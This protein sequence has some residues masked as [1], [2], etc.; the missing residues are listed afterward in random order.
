[1]PKRFEQYKSLGTGLKK[2]E[3]ILGAEFSVWAP[4]AKSVCVVGEFNGWHPGINPMNQVESG[5]FQ[6]FIPGVAAGMKYQY[7]IE[8]LQGK[9]YWKAD[10]FARE[11]EVRPGRSSV[12]SD[13]SAWSW[14]DDQWMKKRRQWDFRTSPLGIYEVHIGSWRKKQDEFYTYREFAHEAAEYVLEMGYTHVELMGI[15]EHPCDA[16]WGYQ[17]TGYYAPTSRYGSVEDFAYMIDYFHQKNIGVI[18]DWVPAHFA[19]DEHGLVNFDGTPVFEYAD[20]LHGNLTAWGTLRFDYGK[21]FVREFLIGN[22]LFWVEEFHLDGLR[23]DAVAFMVYEDYLGYEDSTKCEKTKNRYNFEAIE[24]IK[25]LNK[26]MKAYHPDVL[27][28]A[29]ESSAFPGVT[30][31]QGLEFHMKWNMG[32]MH[33]LLEYV[34]MNQD[35]R[36]KN[37][38]LLTF[39]S[40]YMFDEKYL[41]A[42]SHDEVVHLKKSMLNK[43]SGYMDEKFSDLKVVYAYMIG[44]PGKKLLFM[45]QEFAQYAEWDEKKELDWYLLNDRRHKGVWN[46]WKDL[47]HLYKN[48]QALFQAD[49]EKEGFRWLNADD[50]K[51]SVYS[52]V[53]YGGENK[54]KWMFVCNFSASDWKSYR[55]GVPEWTEY[56]LRIDSNDVKYGGESERKPEVYVPELQEANGENF[57]F[58]F[59]ISAHNALI[60]TF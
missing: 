17:V 48:N 26:M 52:F 30:G 41:L 4:G 15:A 3:G 24:M 33:D 22:A 31:N 54:E 59:D 7:Y 40:S 21:E 8:D 25:C 6:T 44:H 56:K 47:L 18:L 28:I 35:A 11:Y 1:M 53:R 13:F 37:H 60:F 16:S 29:E 14:S 55:L 39:A 19:G 43:A 32:W 9:T 46:Y 51:R 2:K 49:Y 20:G 42:I 38:H 10:P 23:V 45:G 50:Q 58:V 36:A 27:M 5:V 12:I 34:K 57:S